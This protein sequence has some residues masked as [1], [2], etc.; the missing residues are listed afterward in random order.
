V[1]DRPEAMTRTLDLLVELLGSDRREAIDRRLAS[2]RVRLM[3]TA[4]DLADGRTQ[5]AVYVLTSLL[6]RSGMSLEADLAHVVRRV[7]LPGLTGDDFATGL[8]AVV[9]RMLAGAEIRGPTPNPDAILAFGSV[10][11]DSTPVVIRLSANGSTASVGRGHRASGKWDPRDSLSALASAGLAAEEI[12]KDLL[13]PLASRQLDVLEPLE[14]VFDVPIDVNGPIDLGRLVVISAGA[15]S[16]QFLLALTAVEGL[17][18]E[19]VMFD[20]DKTAL[21]NANRCPYV[22][23]DE[24]GRPKVIAIGGLLPVRIRLTPIPNHLSGETRA[25]VP[26]GSAI[27]VGADDISVRHLAQRLDPDWLVIG[28]TSHFLAL[29]TE[30]PLGEPCAGCAHVRLGDEIAVIPTWSIIS[31]WSGFLVAL[32]VIARATGRPYPP[33][34]R[35]T[36]FW[37][38]RPESIFEHELAFSRDCPVQDH[39]EV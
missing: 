26:T 35:V 39:F 2:A 28:A 12:L 33:S 11:V 23:V 31:F 3:V 34:R 29:V 1:S 38:L 21:S 20:R 18:A 16:Q 8:A 25:S 5:A 36:N 22:M 6:V 10:R 17:S 32:R 4:A 19:L 27:V 9:P 14:P 15:I 13:R 30:H 7:D 24:L 37:P